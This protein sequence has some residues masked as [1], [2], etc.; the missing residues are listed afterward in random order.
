MFVWAWL[1][2]AVCHGVLQVSATSC[3]TLKTCRACVRAVPACQWCASDSDIFKK[4]PRCVSATKAF[5][6]AC[7]ADNIQNPHSSIQYI[8]EYNQDFSSSTQ[9]KPQRLKI[10]LRPG[11]QQAFNFSFKPTRNF[12][13]DL[14]FLFDSSTTMRGALETIASDAEKIYESMRIKTTDVR[15]GMGTFV[16]KNAAPFVREKHPK[17]PIS[18]YTH[19][20]TLTEDINKFKVFVNDLA[21]DVKSNYDEREGGFDA[22]A[23]AITCKIGWRDMSRRIIFFFTDAL[24]HTAGDG[25]AAGILYPYDGECHT[26]SNTGIY[27]KELEMDYPSI[28]MISELAQKEGVTIIFFVETSLK[29]HYN[30]IAKHIHGSQMVHFRKY[31]NQTITAEDN[32]S[33]PPEL[34]TLLTEIYTSITKTIKFETIL[35]S[36]QQKHIKISFDPNC[37]GFKSSEK[38]LKCVV[39]MGENTEAVD[40][41]GK[42]MLENYYEEDH[43]Q[44]NINIGSGI[45]EKLMLDID[46][47]DCDCKNKEE[48]KDVCFGHGTKK[49]GVCECDSNSIGDECQCPLKNYGKDDSNCKPDDEN[50]HLPCNGGGHCECGTCRCKPGREGKFCECIVGN[51]VDKCNGHGSCYCGVCTCNPGWGGDTCGCSTQACKAV[52]GKVCNNRGHCE[53]GSCKCDS[54]AAWDARVSQNRDTCEMKPCGNCHVEQC[55]KLEEC[56]K[57]NFNKEADCSHSC[58]GIEVDFIEQLNATDSDKVCDVKVSTGCYTKMRYEYDDVNYRIRLLVQREEDCLI[59]YASTGGIVLVTLVLA[60]L[61]TLVVWK[62]LVDRRDRQEYERFLKLHNVDHQESCQNPIYEPATTTIR[63]PAFRRPSVDFN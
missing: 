28:G 22:L 38:D 55:L 43:I 5:S 56:S 13:A 59:S 47:V 30:A 53:C 58:K 40:Y 37:N 31:R 25:R 29:H 60:G 12:P 15:I 18:S 3:E 48:G 19:K 10:F 54:R 20:L 27:T 7:P 62:W 39:H 52:N 63:N 11:E 45:K 50:E 34:H 4:N 44:L 17:N 61:A 1:C 16:D 51:C 2:L 6:P 33:L 23:Q 14:Y 46:V 57:C 36:E 32:A 8:T 35:S 42:I 24:P 26:D 9:I 41:K 21:N 49:C